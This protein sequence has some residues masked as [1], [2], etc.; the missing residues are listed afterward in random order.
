MKLYSFREGP[1]TFKNA[2]TADPQK[3]GEALATIS[4]SNGGKLETKA[5]V[6][7]A[8]SPKHVLH[9]HFEWDDKVAADRY[10]QETAREMIQVIRVVEDT[11]PQSEQRERRAYL[12]IGEKDGRSYRTVEEVIGSKDLQLKVLQQA[13]RDLEAWQFR[14]AELQEI[15]D[16]VTTARAKLQE[17]IAKAQ[18]EARV[19]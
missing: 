7:A 14:Y 19:Q 12:S 2:K 9:K 1:L 8:T 5:V 13:E 10:R 11:K 18:H 3:I 17:R 6:S 4:I 16:I 15:C